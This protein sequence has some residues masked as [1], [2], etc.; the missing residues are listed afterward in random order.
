MNNGV[1]GCN[2]HLTLH[3][4]WSKLVVR[5][6]LYHQCHF[7]FFFWE[8]IINAKLKQRFTKAIV[9]HAGSLNQTVCLFCFDIQVYYEIEVKYKQSYHKVRKSKEDERYDYPGKPMKPTNSR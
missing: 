6:L 1:G 5:H 4:Y 7:F 2:Y 9:R 8:K 3:L